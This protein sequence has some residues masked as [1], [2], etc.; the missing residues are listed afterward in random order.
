MEN[1]SQLRGGKGKLVL[2]LSRHA[3]HSS[4]YVDEMFALV[5][6]PR[7]WTVA[8]GNL[9]NGDSVDVSRSTRKRDRLDWMVGVSCVT[10]AIED[11]HSLGERSVVDLLIAE[12]CMLAPS[13]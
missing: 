13:L 8:A 5:A 7:V 2:E 11:K 6:F 3:E 1:I 9:V 10:F 12:W 4:E